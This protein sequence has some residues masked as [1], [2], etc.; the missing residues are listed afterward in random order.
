MSD[1]INVLAEENSDMRDRN[2]KKFIN[3]KVGLTFLSPPRA[4]KH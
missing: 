3:G 1:V 2:L 4:A